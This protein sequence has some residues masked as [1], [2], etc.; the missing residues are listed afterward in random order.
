MP[1]GLLPTAYHPSDI[2]DEPVPVDVSEPKI[3]TDFE[4]NVPLQT[5][6]VHEEYISPG[7]EYLQES[8]ELQTHV[9]SNKTIKRYLP[10]HANWD[11]ILRI[12]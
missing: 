6:I 7:K 5:G 11:K 10:K 8:P 1:V 3:N 2:E 9:D 4:E 12:I